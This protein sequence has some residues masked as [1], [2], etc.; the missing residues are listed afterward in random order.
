GTAEIT[1]SVDS[2]QSRSAVWSFAHRS[3]F[4]FTFSFIVLALLPFP[5][6]AGSFYETTLYQRMWFAAASWISTHLQ[7]L[8]PTPSIAAPYTLGD[9]I[10]GH[11]ELLCFVVGAALAA[12]FWTLLDRK[13]PNYR[14]LYEWLRI[15]V[16]YA[17]AFAMLGYGM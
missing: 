14:T 8:S 3:V 16:R 6:G 2:P 5:F 10:I 4:R 17:L 1:F 11:V 15:Y 7:H 9:N 13:R 12:I